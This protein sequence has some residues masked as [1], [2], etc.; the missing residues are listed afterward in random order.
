MEFLFEVLIQYGGELLLQLLFE[1]AAEAGLH[2][3]GETFRQ[4]RNPLIATIGFALWGLITGGIS[5]LLFPHSPIT[6]PHWRR[7]NLIVT[8]I[9]AGGVMAVIGSLRRRKG[10]RL[11]RLDRFGYAYLF[12][13]V[14]ALV[15]YR[16]AG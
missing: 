4:P 10:L 3:L 1:T 2:S 14:M 13:L 9:L 11:V 12:A 7:I 5:L 8:P 6:D 15:R 16:W